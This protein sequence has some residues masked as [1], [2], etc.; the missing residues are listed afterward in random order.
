MSL[1]TV[2]AVVTALLFGGMTFYALVMV[3]LIFAKLPE[4]TR[5]EFLRAVFPVYYLVMAAVAFLAAVLTYPGQPTDGGLL[6]LVAFGF[7]AAR[8]VLMPRINDVR[9]GKAAGDPAA[10][11]TFDNL[12]RLSVYLN[13]AQLGLVLW[14]LTKMVK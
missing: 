7:I 1:A 11:R 5:D 14:V 4:G 8:Q 3:P 9:A 10:T 6:M 13:A 2:A 12:H